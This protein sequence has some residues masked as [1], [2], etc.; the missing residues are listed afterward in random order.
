M[1]FKLHGLSFL[2]VLHRLFNA[3]LAFIEIILSRL[4][5]LFKSSKPIAS[6]NPRSILIL[7]YMGLGDAVL[8]MPTLRALR[9]HF[10]DAEFSVVYSPQSAARKVFEYSG[11]LTNFF[12]L[13]YKTTSVVNRY[14]VLWALHQQ[15]FDCVFCTQTSPIEY[16][17]PLL[18]SIPT[19]V[20]HIITSHKRWKPRPNWLFTL[21]VVLDPNDKNLEA[22]RY[23]RLVQMLVPG[24]QFHYSSMDLTFASPLSQRPHSAPAESI[25]IGIHCVSPRFPWKHW[26]DERYVELAVKLLERKETVLLFLGE[27]HERPFITAIIA[28]ITEK[29][30]FDG[31]RLL[32]HTPAVEPDAPEPLLQTMSFLRSC[33]VLVA[34]DGGIAHIAVSL[35][36]PVVRLFGMSDYYGFRS[37]DPI[38]QDIWKAVPCSPCFIL[39]ALVPGKNLTNCGRYIC[40]ESITIDEVLEAVERRLPQTKG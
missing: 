19:R 11:I 1:P 18:W 39:G 16:F 12:M 37:P 20:G 31:T 10:P 14:K 25:I 7:G 8:F 15:R 27:P 29:T 30:P 33:S 32:I 24:L 17:V 22:E 9:R 6:S 28:M 26:G 3:G 4:L 23:F 13:D 5:I 38:H 35:Q 36:V 34:H 40:L 21:S 2:P